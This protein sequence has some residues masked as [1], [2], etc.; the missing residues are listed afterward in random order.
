LSRHLGTGSRPTSRSGKGKLARIVFTI[1]RLTLVAGLVLGLPGLISGEGR[2]DRRRVASIPSV[3]API[4]AQ[5]TVSD[6]TPAS[7][8]AQENVLDEWPDLFG[9]GQSLQGILKGGPKGERGPLVETRK[10]I[11][12]RTP[13]PAIL[14]DSP[15][16]AKAIE[17]R[18]IDEPSEKK[19]TSA[20]V[21]TTEKISPPKIEAT[22]KIDEPKTADPEPKREVKIPATVVAKADPPPV[23][24]PQPEETDEAPTEFESPKS[25]D[26]KKDDPPLAQV[27]SSK[28][29]EPDTKGAAISKKGYTIKAENGVLVVYDSGGNVVLRN[30]KKKEPQL[31]VAKSEETSDLKE[32]PSVSVPV[33]PQ[34]FVTVKKGENLSV[35]ASRY[36]GVS[37]DDLME[38]NQIDDPYS[39]QIGQ[40]IWIPT[41]DVEGVCH[42]VQPGETLSDLVKKYEIRSL[43]EICDLNGLKRTQNDLEPG[44][45]LVLPG[46]KPRP[47]QFAKSQSKAVQEDLSGIRGRVAWAWPL[48][49]K[50]YV[51][52]NYGLRVDPFSHARKTGLGAGEPRLAKSMHSGIDLAISPGS[53]VYAARAGEVVQAGYRGRHGRS[54]TIRHDDGWSTVYSHLSKSLVKVGDRVQQGQQIAR[55]GNTG[56]STGPHLHFEIRRPDQT[57]LN[58]RKLLGPLPT[59]AE[60]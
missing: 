45:L 14:E 7:D 26:T 30:D 35:I 4:S 55:S 49:G 42:K 20:P 34:V 48:E 44:K 24:V 36:D 37:A 23:D 59:L 31:G 21:V 52:S 41:N 47:E 8:G 29:A 18:K 56:R 11:S 19:A 27:E 57:A 33:D 32:E 58:P 15:A 51:S 54:I 1:S 3:L 28:S 43:F 25:A 13:S 40:R 16:E 12:P 22:G 46:A 50:F 39:I 6:E 53:A 2:D 17:P 60:H 10:P 38:V 9:E 5:A